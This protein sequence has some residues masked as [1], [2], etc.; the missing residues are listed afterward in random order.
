MKHKKTNQA[1][2]YLWTEEGERRQAMVAEV[3]PLI[4]THRTYSFLIE[5]AM[6]GS[7]S[8]GQRVMVPLGRRGKLVMG[9]V[10]G[11]DRRTWDSTLRAI[12][13]VVDAISFV[14]PDLIQ[15]AREIAV[16]YACPLGQTL[17]AI[18]PEAVRRQRGLK[19]V[20]YARLLVSVEEVRASGKRVSAKRQVLIDAL[21]ERSDPMAVDQ[22]LKEAGAS[23][24]VLRA[25]AKE[26]WIEIVKRKELPTDESL[27]A[28]LLEPTFELN[29]EQSAALGKI[30]T[31]LDEGGFSVTLLFGVSGSGKTEVYVHAIRRV[32][33]SGRQAILLVPEIVLTTQMVQR[34][35]A[36]FADVAVSH[37][38][39]SDVQRSII[40][41]QVARGEKKVV[42]GTRSAVFAPCPDLGLICV[43][44]E[45]ETSYKNLQAPRFHVRDVAIMRAK[46]LGIPV[47]LGSATP[48]VE[49][50][51]NSAHRSDYE[52]IT[53]PS[54]VRSLP[55]PDVHVIDM[56][57]ECAELK[58]DVILSRPMERLL[59]E[60]LERG[61]QA[62]ILMNRR[63]FS[64]CLY[65]PA[66]ETRVEC[67]NCNVG[68]VAHSSTGQ[69]I[70]HYCRSRIPTPTVCQNAGCGHALAHVGLGTQR[71][72]DVLAK[73]FPGTR[74]ERVDSDTMKHRSEYQ[75]IVDDFEARKTD[76]LVGTQMIAKGLDFPFVSFVGVVNADLGGFA[77]DFRAHERL[78]QLITQ[79]AGRAG[80]ADAAGKVVVQT[81]TADIPALNHALKYDYESFA[82]E[83]IATR[84]RVGLPP[85][86]RLARVVLA[87]EREEAVRQEAASLAER[88]R[89]AIESLS[90]EASDVLGPNPC[91]LSRLR[92]R[93]RH[94]LLVRTPNAS[95]MR[96]LLS[97]LESKNT[98]RTKLKS[99]IIDVDPVSLT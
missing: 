40:W 91:A 17:K 49:T 72:E 56:R 34:L 69:S 14:S 6:E 26:G 93:Y 70:C 51:Y 29:D 32:V 61:E 31:R 42:I 86:R 20:R 48:A 13:H 35:A 96:C 16:H 50:W 36:R 54:R 85:F 57:D 84:Q 3:A 76:V 7:I 63:G 2:G 99:T 10:V 23:S 9:F 11:L 33:E 87:G 89:A 46:Q 62:L 88:I 4:P 68:L 22:L 39:L 65:C 27:A 24:A 67:P 79:V 38:G 59:G 77:S 12:D 44:E 52:R 47:V 41:Q 75:R 28:E 15:L 19:T 82:A 78:F 74:I 83:E 45:Q 73:R 80:R 92:G 71:V 30:N 98:L 60:T 58:R 97:Q 94:D 37:S 66:C 25:A 81:T 90:L 95:T 43:D 64:R 53:I 18:T 8:A 21:A 1:T 55:M 5:P